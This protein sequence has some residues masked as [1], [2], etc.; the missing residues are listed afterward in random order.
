MACSTI[1]RDI[2][3]SAKRIYTQRVY[4]PLTGSRLS[5][6]S[7]VRD[8]HGF[9]MLAEVGRLQFS[10]CHARKV[11][12]DVTAMPESATWW[13]RQKRLGAAGHLEEKDGRPFGWSMQAVCPVDAVSC[14][15]PFV[16]L[17]PSWKH[18]RNTDSPLR[19]APANRCR[20][21]LRPPIDPDTHARNRY[22][23]ANA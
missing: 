11:D 1:R 23:P 15:F 3:R 13:M 20:G 2:T 12:S 8:R 7:T 5:R 19:Y 21:A 22:A 18:P 6:L 14:Q 17:Q 10:A 16:V 9:S 4:P